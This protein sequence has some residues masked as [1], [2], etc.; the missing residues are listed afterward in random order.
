M[1]RLSFV[2]TLLAITAT[3]YAEIPQQRD[4][5]ACDSCYPGSPGTQCQAQAGGVCYNLNA[6]GQCPAGTSPCPGVVETGPPCRDLGKEVIDQGCTEAFPTCVY[7]NGGQ[8]VGG[9]GGH[10]CA[11]CINSRFPSN[12]GQVAPDEGCDEEF[13]VCVGSRPL[14]ANVE[15][16]AC[17]LCVNSISAATDPNDIDDGCPPTAPICV[18]DSGQ[19]PALRTFGTKCVANCVDTSRL[20]ADRGCPRGYP[21]CTTADGADPGQGNAGVQCAVCSP[22]LCDDNDPCT[23]DICDP[24]VGC[25]HVDNGSCSCGGGVVAS[26]WQCTLPTP[27]CTQY[28]RVGVYD[29][30]CD[31]DVEG[32]PFCWRDNNCVNVASCSSNADC[33]PTQR[34]AS[35]CCGDGHCFEDCALSEGSNESRRRLTP[36]ELFGPTGAHF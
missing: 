32:S 27:I 33:G 11:L 17:A 8:V 34:C 14:A 24:L 28:P 20:G 16:T 36:A 7:A 25:S 35:S 1:V 12:A 29:C 5:Q 21:I 4:L 10:H 6:S 3:A 2:G 22:L 19:S 13:R 23:D 30:I 18:N 9:L 15:G 26:D 31:V